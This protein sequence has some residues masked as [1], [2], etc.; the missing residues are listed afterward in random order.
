MSAL[1]SS[2]LSLFHTTLLRLDLIARWML[3]LLHFFELELNVV[4]AA[5]AKRNWLAISADSY[6]RKEM[7]ARL[8]CLNLFESHDCFIV[9]TFF[10]KLSNQN[11]WKWS[12]I[13][14]EKCSKINEVNMLYVNRWIDVTRRICELRIGRIRKGHIVILSVEF[15]SI[16]LIVTAA[17]L[18]WFSLTVFKN[19]IFVFSN[20]III[21]IFIIAIIIYIIIIII[22]FFLVLCVILL[23]CQKCLLLLVMILRAIL[24]YIRRGLFSLIGKWI[25]IWMDLRVLWWRDRSEWVW[26]SDPRELVWKVVRMVYG[27]IRLKTIMLH[28]CRASLILKNHVIRWEIRFFI[29]FVSRFENAVRRWELNCFGF[30]HFSV[31]DFE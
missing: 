5:V 31:L 26:W 20:N 3:V 25:S 24:M 11:R 10:I 1:N 19:L 28:L 29:G 15:I 23:L 6:S 14:W 30:F 2:Q 8:K 21:F 18:T 12:I 4:A 13:I 9:V 27:G 16:L 17:I 22:D 7:L